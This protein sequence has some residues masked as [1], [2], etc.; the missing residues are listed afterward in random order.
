[1]KNLLVHIHQWTI[2]STNHT[3][4]YQYLLTCTGETELQLKLLVAHNPQDATLYTDNRLQIPP[5]PPKPAPTRPNTPTPE[6]PGLEAPP[7]NISRPCRDAPYY[8]QQ[9]LQ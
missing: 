9:G 2:P 5:P 6:S 3:L 7:Q 1:M 4:P 8:D